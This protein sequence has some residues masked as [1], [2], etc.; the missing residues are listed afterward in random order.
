M[1]LVDW[2]QT[3]VKHKQTFNHDLIVQ[4]LSARAVGRGDAHQVVTGCIVSRLRVINPISPTQERRLHSTS[5][6]VLCRLI[7]ESCV[8]EAFHRQLQ[9][10][11]K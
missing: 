3:S 8:T 5:V 6:V 7:S 2:K 1:S 11:C 10:V 4:I 9:F